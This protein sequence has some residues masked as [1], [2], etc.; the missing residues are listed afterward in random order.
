M[1]L[2]RPLESQ[3]EM[4]RD[5]ADEL[6]TCAE[7]LTTEQKLSFFWSARQTV[8]CGKLYLD[9][10]KPLMPHDQRTTFATELDALELDLLA[11]RTEL[12]F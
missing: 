10:L 2:T 1:N 3:L 4:A 12:A 8:T 7:D 6:V 9:A 5:L 11:I